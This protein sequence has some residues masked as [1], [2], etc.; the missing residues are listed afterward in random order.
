MLSDI[1]STCITLV[2][3]KKRFF[4]HAPSSAKFMPEFSHLAMESEFW[5]QWSIGVVI[6]EIF[7]G[8]DLVLGT[9]SFDDLAK[10]FQDCSEYLDVPSWTLIETLMFKQDDQA[11]SKAIKG[12][13]MAPTDL[14]RISIRKVAMA[15]NDDRN[16]CVW[17]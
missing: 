7:V 5:D 8:S 14:T 17:K 13:M 9:N 12:Y 15:L 6:L 2:E 11:L 3:D 16:L 4:K 1:K 10:L